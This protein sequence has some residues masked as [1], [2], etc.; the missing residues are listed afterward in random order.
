MYFVYLVAGVLAA[1]A[2]RGARAPCHRGVGARRAAVVG[3][4]ARS[5]PPLVRDWAP[6]A[7]ILAGYFL[8]G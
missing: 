3:D 7:Y 5:A 6:L 2:A 1:A 4:R 8:S